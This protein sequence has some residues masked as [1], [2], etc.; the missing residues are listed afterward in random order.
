MKRR[1]KEDKQVIADSVWWH[2]VEV[3]F[4]HWK[5]WGFTDR[6][7]GQFHTP[8]GNLHLTGEQRDDILNA[9]YARE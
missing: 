3:Y 8:S 7:S 6:I 4:P 1:S 9:I 5:L 2:Q